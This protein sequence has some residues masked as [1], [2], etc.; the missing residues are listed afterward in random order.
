MAERVGS[1]LEGALPDE[2]V[3]A[4]ARRCRAARTGDKRIGERRGSAR[5]AARD[6]KG[7]GEGSAPRTSS[8]R[9]TAKGLAWRVASADA[10]DG[11][12]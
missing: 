5:A 9:R 8:R 7:R 11:G 4:A 6:E 1:V 12:E 10:R 3:G 2:R